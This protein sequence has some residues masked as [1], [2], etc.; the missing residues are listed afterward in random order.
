[1]PD[2]SLVYK[3]ESKGDVADTVAIGE[4]AGE[5]KV[6]AEAGEKFS[7]ISVKISPQQV[8]AQLTK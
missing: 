7:K 2:G 5:K 3:T 4:A 8:F 6:N 1:M